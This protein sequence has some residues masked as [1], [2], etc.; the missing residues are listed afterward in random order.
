MK[1][2][3]QAFGRGVN[4]LG[5]DRNGHDVFGEDEFGRWTGTEL[6]P[7]PIYD[8]DDDGVRPHSRRARLFLAIGWSRGELWEFFARA[9]SAASVEAYLRGMGLRDIEVYPY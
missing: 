7:F 9:E 3:K 8:K 5:Q 4:A 2:R 1:R 6:V